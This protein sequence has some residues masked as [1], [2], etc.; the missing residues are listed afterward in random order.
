MTPSKRLM[1]VLNRLRGTVMSRDRRG[2]F[3]S[4]MRI[5]GLG[6][7]IIWGGAVIGAAA[8]SG[9]LYTLIPA[10]GGPSS[11]YQQPAAAQTEQRS[12]DRSN[13][14]QQQQTGTAQNPAGAQGAG[15]NP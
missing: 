2:R 10:Q 1:R 5:A 15:G 4:L 9:C 13:S 7:G 11:T 8:C 6:P 12:G 14:K 3:L